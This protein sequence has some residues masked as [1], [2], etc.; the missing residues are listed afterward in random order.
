VESLGDFDIPKWS[1]VDTDRV[2]ASLFLVVMYS[3][4]AAGDIVDESLEAV[5]LFTKRLLLL[6]DIC[7]ADPLPRPP[8]P[9]RP[10][11]AGGDG[12]RT[13]QLFYPVTRIL[14]DKNHGSSRSQRGL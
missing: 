5:P 12:G 10:G 11:M 9:L 1:A 14:N 3:L 7:W 13:Q 8:R 4:A 6:A 2:F